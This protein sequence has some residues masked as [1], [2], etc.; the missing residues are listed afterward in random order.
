MY[1]R[2][3]YQWCC[4]TAT[5]D[6]M[7]YAAAF[8]PENNH[9]EA[10]AIDGLRVIFQTLEEATARLESK[11]IDITSPVHNMLSM[12]TQVAYT[13]IM[14][15]VWIIIDNIRRIDLLLK[16]I[17]GIPGSVAGSSFSSMI[18]EIKSL[19]DSLH[20]IDERIKRFYK[21]S[22]EPVLGQIMWSSRDTIDN[23]E[24]Y[25][26]LYSGVQRVAGNDLTANFGNLDPTTF[27]GRIGVYNLRI[28]YIAVQV[29]PATKART[30][31]KFVE[32]NLEQAISIV[33]RIIIF[34]N[35]KYLPFYNTSVA[36]GEHPP[37]NL[38]PF[39]AS[40]RFKS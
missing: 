35:K 31:E 26:M 21:I 29:D 15:D 22:T 18:D 32:V 25:H 34:I 40:A 20:H 9:V 11:L 13:S 6:I 7:L 37:E 33:N 17:P 28:R 2:V 24:E 1:L 14:G 10:V 30:P 5:S 12:A 8:L 4:D 39:I 19:R 36:S 16:F 27:I 38:L 23:I 3:N